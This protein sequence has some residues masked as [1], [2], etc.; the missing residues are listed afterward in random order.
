M[1]GASLESRKPRPKRP[2]ENRTSNEAEAAG[3]L[4]SSK[5]VP[6]NC[7]ETTKQTQ[8]WFSLFLEPLQKSI[9]NFEFPANFKKSKQTLFLKILSFG[10]KAQFLAR[11][12]SKKKVTFRLYYHVTSIVDLT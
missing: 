5:M 1:K 8:G 6:I 10:E 11:L 3:S 2:K 7:K 9:T 4:T 12:Q